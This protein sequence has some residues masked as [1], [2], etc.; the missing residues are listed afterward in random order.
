[1]T[2]PPKIRQLTSHHKDLQ[3]GHH[4]NGQ[5]LGFAKLAG[6]ILGTVTQPT[7][8]A[9]EKEMKGPNDAA[10]D[11]P[12]IAGAESLTLQGRPKLIC[13]NDH[14]LVVQGIHDGP[15]HQNGHVHG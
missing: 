10:K 7:G 6:N 4:G 12:G 8:Q 15:R 11:L 3:V 2:E 1:M 14:P 5:V 9:Q 13:Q